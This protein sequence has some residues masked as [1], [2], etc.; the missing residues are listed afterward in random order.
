MLS[1]RENIQILI[2]LDVFTGCFLRLIT[3]NVWKKFLFL[4]LNPIS[5]LRNGVLVCLLW[6]NLKALKYIFIKTFQGFIKRNLW[7]NRRMT[8]NAM[9]NPIIVNLLI[10]EFLLR[11]RSDFKKWFFCPPKC[12]IYKFWA[13]KPLEVKCKNVIWGC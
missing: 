7:E 9:S 8:A 3:L 1:F 10:F 2:Y 13:Y 5:Y 12:K 11:F 6:M 4:I